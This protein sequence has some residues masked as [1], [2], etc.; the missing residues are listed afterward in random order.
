MKFLS[1]EVSLYL[2]KSTILPCMEYCYHIWAGAP[3]CYLDLLDISYKKGCARLL[4][5]HLLLLLNP[6]PMVEIRPAE[7]FSIGITD[8]D[9][10]GRGVFFWTLTFHDKFH[11]SKRA[12][13]SSKSQKIQLPRSPLFTSDVIKVEAITWPW[14]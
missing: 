3:S 13:S 10:T 14:L 1:C 5:F 12:I 6:W 2:Y 4:V 8:D 9:Y 11:W 7:A